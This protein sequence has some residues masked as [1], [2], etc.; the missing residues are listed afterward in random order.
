MGRVTR[1]EYECDWCEVIATDGDF[2]ELPTTWTHIE[3]TYELLCPE[4]HKARD[5]AIK[6]ARD[7]RKAGIPAEHKSEGTETKT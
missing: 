6:A 7:A 5:V 4:C 3:S 2:D 1:V